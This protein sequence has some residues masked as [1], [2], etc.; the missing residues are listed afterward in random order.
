M[1]QLPDK[2]SE[3]DRL[4]FKLSTETQRRIQA[5]MAGLQGAMQNLIK[6]HGQLRTERDTLDAA[7]KETYA[8]APGDKI[9][10]DGTIQ[11]AAV[12]A[13]AEGE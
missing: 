5:E 10:D 12:R 11:R 8:L 7:F 2:L 6:Q 1:S 4:K 3:V 9:M 13:I